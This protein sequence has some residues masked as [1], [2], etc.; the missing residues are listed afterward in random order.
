MAVN[1]TPWLCL[2]L[3]LPLAAGC[4]GTATVSGTV[5]YDGKLVEHGKIRFLPMD[6]KGDL[7][8][9]GDIVGVDIIKGKYT[10]KEVPMGKK[11]VAIDAEQLAGQTGPT[12]RDAKGDPAQAVEPLIPAEASRDLTVEINTLEQTQ[13]FDLK[14]PTPAAGDAERKHRP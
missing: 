11:K 10:A 7:D 12:A 5:T 8:P 13:N 6:D 4:G 14:K 3:L 2:V 1:K 9:K